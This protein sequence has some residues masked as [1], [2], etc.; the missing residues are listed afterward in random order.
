MAHSTATHFVSPS[1]RK[2]FEED[3]EDRK[4]MEVFKKFGCDY[5]NFVYDQGEDGWGF[6][7]KGY[8]LACENIDEIIPG[9]FIFEKSDSTLS[10]CVTRDA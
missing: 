6:D 7:I 3:E 1:I 9:T 8:K 10:L 5:F 2:L 4:I